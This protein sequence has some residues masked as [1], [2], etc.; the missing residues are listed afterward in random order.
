M[1]E[2]SYEIIDEA[3]TKVSADGLILY[4]KS[5]AEIFLENDLE[6]KIS[7]HSTFDY[8]DPFHSNDIQPALNDTKYWNKGDLFISL[9]SISFKHIDVFDTFFTSSLKKSTQL[10][11]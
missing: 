1:S 5:I 4:Q 11:E 7:K 3:I 10:D 9:G 2:Y 8:L 6:Y